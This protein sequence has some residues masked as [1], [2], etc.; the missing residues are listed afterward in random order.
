MGQPAGVHCSNYA[1]RYKTDDVLSCE[2]VLS[3]WRIDNWLGKIDFSIL[4][5][6]CFALIYFY[7]LFSIDFEARDENSGSFFWI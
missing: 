7:I 3:V 5:V 6:C 4:T 1:I 2:I